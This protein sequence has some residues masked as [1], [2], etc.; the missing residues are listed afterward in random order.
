MCL[1][2]LHHGTGFDLNRS[3]REAPSTTHVS[4]DRRR[5]ERTALGTSIPIEWE[6]WHPSNREGTSRIGAPVGPRSPRPWRT[7]LTRS[8]WNRDRIERGGDRRV[9]P[10]TRTNSRADP[11]SRCHAGEG[12]VAISR[13]PEWR[14]RCRICQRPP[15]VWVGSWLTP[16]SPHLARVTT[17]DVV[18]AMHI[19][20]ET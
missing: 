7:C 11:Y 3:D 4:H 13:T 8:D 18:Y 6:R 2:G 1:A 19:P 17:E 12:G 5:I 9:R 14:H 16:D 15:G 10:S 20:D